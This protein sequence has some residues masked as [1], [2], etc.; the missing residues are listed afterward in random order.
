M[1]SIWL[2]NKFYVKEYVKLGRI[3]YV[4]FEKIYALCCGHYFKNL[5]HIRK[6]VYW[7]S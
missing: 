6:Y 7:C 4:I 2:F 3:I 1:I 5:A